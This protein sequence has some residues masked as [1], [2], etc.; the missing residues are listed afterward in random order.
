MGGEVQPVHP[1]EP[2]RPPHALPLSDASPVLDLPRR[3]RAHLV[4]TGTPGLRR[5]H[6][7]VFRLP[8]SW[9]AERIRG[10]LLKLGIVVSKRSVQ[11]YLLT[12]QTV[13]F[14]TLYV[15]VFINHHRRELVHLN[16]TSSPTA[17]WVWQQ[18]IAATPWG[19]SPSYLVRDR[20]AV[21]SRDFAH[22]A[23]R[24]GIETVL[25]PVRA[26]RAN[27]VA[28]RVIGTL[29]RECLDHVILIN[30]SHLRAV[31]TE[32]TSYYNRDRPHR[33]LALQTPEPS[34]RPRS[35]PVRARPVLGGLH[36]AYERAA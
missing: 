19:C 24:L 15:I 18:V 20:D 25:T 8:V 32:F 10:E 9:G 16:V 13:T 21:Y 4:R 29:R 1:R 34:V 36:R 14:R 33:T 31:V 27:A 7:T 28:E 26:P 2:G 23:R 12:V 6:P 5:D 22:R 17:A 30:E 11:Q 3:G 35:G